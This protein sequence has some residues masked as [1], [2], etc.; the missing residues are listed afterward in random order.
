MNGKLNL[1]SSDLI[2]GSS[3]GIGL[4]GTLTGEWEFGEGVRVMGRGCGLVMWVELVSG[5]M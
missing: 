5:D 3:Q 1:E 2:G 4:T